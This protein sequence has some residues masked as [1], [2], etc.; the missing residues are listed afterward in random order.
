MKKH[1]LSKH[2][3]TVKTANFP[4]TNYDFKNQ[5][6][7]YDEDKTMPVISQMFIDINKNALLHL[8]ITWLT[9][10][11]E[12]S[13]EDEFY[14]L[15]PCLVLNKNTH[16]KC[17]SYMPTTIITK[18]IENSD[19]DEFENYSLTTIKTFAIENSDDDEF[20]IM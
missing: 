8:N 20:L 7:F 12:N 11:V 4:T 2:S 14:M 13:D 1:I 6:S 15:K 18:A 5:I 16:Q 10:A 3:K 9:E 19:N 17:S